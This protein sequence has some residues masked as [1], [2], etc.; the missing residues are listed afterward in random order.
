MDDL[1]GIGHNCGLFPAHTEGG[2]LGRVVRRLRKMDQKLGEFIQVCKDLG[3][4]DHMSFILTSDHGMAPFGRQ[5][6]GLDYDGRSRLPD[7]VDSIRKSGYK[8]E[9]LAEGE[10]PEYDT[11]IVI[12]TAGLEVQL[13]FTAEFTREDIEKVIN[14]V[15]DKP[16]IGR[17]MKKEEMMERGAL[18]GFADLLISPEVPYSFQTGS[19]KYRAGGQHDSLDESAQHIFSIMWGRGIRKGY[20]YESRMYNIDFARTMAKLLDIGGPGNATG[21]VLEDAL[22][23]I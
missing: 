15:K 11:D 22:T 14:R 12:V 8:T 4:Y 16:Y 1:D 3:I 13:S 5:G 20:V 17:I 21:R 6:A 10:T 19:G 23:D 9:V 7:L 18:E 2:R